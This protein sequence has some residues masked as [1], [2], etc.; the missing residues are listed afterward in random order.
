MP[1]G[2][3]H[4][5]AGDIDCVAGVR[6]GTDHRLGMTATANLE[7]DLHAGLAH[8]EIDAFA[9]MF[10]LDQIGT[11]L[12]KQR[13]QPGQPTGPIADSGEQDQPPAGLG[14]VSPDQ[15]V[16]DFRRRDGAEYYKPIGYS[17]AKSGVLNFTR[18]LA[19]YCAPF[20]VR[21]LPA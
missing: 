19:E 18:W 12:G 3:L 1:P 2:S 9:D 6:G 10:D 4:L 15:S 7:H 5:L 16:Y 20:G 17:V 14:L 8:V 21:V 13:Q 11:V